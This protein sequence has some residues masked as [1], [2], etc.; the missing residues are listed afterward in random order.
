MPKN[1]MLCSR[2]YLIADILPSIPLSPNPGATITPFSLLNFLDTL[3][4]LIF[5][6]CIH[7]MFTLQKLFA[8][9]CIIASEIDL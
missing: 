2:I 6:A 7:F 8:P 5:S 4:L 1:G 9:A 3:L